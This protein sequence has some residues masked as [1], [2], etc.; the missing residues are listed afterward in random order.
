MLVIIMRSCI[1][2][3]MGAGLGVYIVVGVMW[4]VAVQV[5]VVGVFV[6]VVVLVV[7]V[8]VLLG[9]QQYI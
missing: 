4:V 7:A 8:E 5:A 1:N 6:A 3:C 2:I 9:N